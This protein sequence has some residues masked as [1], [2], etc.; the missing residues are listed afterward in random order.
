MGNSIKYRGANSDRGPSPNLWHDCPWSDLVEDPNLGYT[1]FDD[2]VSGWGTTPTIT[3]AV[4]LGPYTAFGSSGATITYETDVRGGVVVLTE[5]TDN[6]AISL[7]TESLPFQISADLGKLW[8]EARIKTSTITADEQAWFVGLAGAMTQ[9]A[10]VP[11]TAAGAL[12]DINIC[13]FHQ[14]EGNTTAFDTSYKANGVTAVEV[15]SDVGTLAVDTFVK[16]GMKFDPKDS[17]QLTFYIDGS[18]QAS[19]QT[20][21]DD[22]GTDF[23]ADVQ[24][25]LAIAK[26]MANGASETLHMDWWRAAQLAS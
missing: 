4:N 14:P 21:P 2:F 19:K 25:G 5:A 26:V 8:F 16:L 10:T 13:G 20:I 17:N 22:T 3:T 12:A 7:I 23:P 18:E 15:N 11:L 1:F 24:M 6:E 9:S